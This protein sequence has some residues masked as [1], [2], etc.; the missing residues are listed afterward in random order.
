MTD[1]EIRA[2]TFAFVQRLRERFGDRIPSD[3]LSAGIRVSGQRVPIWNYQ[4]GIF[5]P[6]KLGRHGA[7]LS[8]QTSAKSPYADE[9]DPDA[10]HF[11]YMYRGSDPNQADNAA[12]RAAMLENKPLVYLQAVDPGFYDAIFPV[13]VIGDDP[14][15][16]QF[17]LVADQPGTIVSTGVHRDEPMVM[18]R[19][20]YVTRAVMARLHQQRFRHLVL[21]AYHDRCAVCRLAHRELLDAAHILADRHPLGEP[22][23]SNGLG[24]CKIHHSAYDW[25]ILGIDADAR[26][27]I[28]GDILDEK[29]GPML[30]HGLQALHMTTLKLPRRPDHKPNRDFLEERFAR[31]RA[32]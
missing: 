12:L 23:I 2:A 7:A 28:R 30:K 5:K 1:D 3:E 14:Q 29:D 13:Y 25:N 17:T 26:V 21:D 11:V 15:R 22:V 24:M 32:A 10:G 6:G 20:E 9:H 8:I 27:H 31:F 16:L 4:R 19:R 18:I